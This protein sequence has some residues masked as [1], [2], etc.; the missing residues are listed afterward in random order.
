MKFTLHTRSSRSLIG[1]F[2]SFTRIT[3]GL[4]GRFGSG[5]TGFIVLGNGLV[6]AWGMV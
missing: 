5:S 4:I 1:S 3:D 6:I 2:S